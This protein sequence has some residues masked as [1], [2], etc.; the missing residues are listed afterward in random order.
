MTATAPRRCYF[1]DQTMLTPAGYSPS[2]V[3]EGEPGHTRTTITWGT[4]FDA[5]RAAAD[6]INAQLGHTRTDVLEIIASS[7]AASF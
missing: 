7:M 3:T 6:S 4:D 2:I 1:L 5:A